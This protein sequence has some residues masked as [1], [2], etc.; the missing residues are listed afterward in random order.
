MQTAH[1]HSS[2]FIFVHLLSIEQSRICL[3]YSSLGYSKSFWAIPSVQNVSKM[4]CQR[5][6]LRQKP[7]GPLR[8]A[9]LEVESKKTK[10][11]LTKPNIWKGMADYGIKEAIILAVSIL[12]NLRSNWRHSAH[13]SRTSVGPRSRRKGEKFRH[14]MTLHD[15][16]WHFMTFQ[17]FSTWQCRH[18]RFKQL[19]KSALPRPHLNISKLSLPKDQ[20]SPWLKQPA[21]DRLWTCPYC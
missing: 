19:C 9:T 2:S 21:N 15:I 17:H 13:R 20:T 11:K 18:F 4:S 8:C 6:L 5:P 7:R 3:L 1:L 14:F 16:S 10:I 12:P